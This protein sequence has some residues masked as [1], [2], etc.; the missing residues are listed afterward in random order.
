[1]LAYSSEVLD[2]RATNVLRHGSFTYPHRRGVGM[3]T[4]GGD[5]I[6]YQL[7]ASRPLFGNGPAATLASPPESAAESP[8]LMLVAWNTL[9]LRILVKITGRTDEVWGWQNCIRSGSGFKGVTWLSRTLPGSL[10]EVD[11]IHAARV[12]RGRP[13]RSGYWR[14]VSNGAPRVEG[15]GT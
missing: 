14:T 12:T 10:N 6:Y 4:D 3:V 9:T 5:L 1:M 11:D 8:L 7:A 2:S 13:A 15:P